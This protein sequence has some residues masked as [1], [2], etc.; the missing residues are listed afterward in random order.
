M[1]IL[2]ED[3][4]K[5]LELNVSV[6][7]GIILGIE[8]RRIEMPRDN[9]RTKLVTFVSLECHRGHRWDEDIV[10]LLKDDYPTWCKLC[11]IAEYQEELERIVTEKGGKL[12]TNYVNWRT[13]V[14]VWCGVD[15]HPPWDVAPTGIKNNGGWC[16]ICARSYFKEICNNVYYVKEEICRE[17]FYEAFHTEFKRTRS[18]DFMK[19][20]ELDGYSSKYNVAFEYNGEQHYFRI[21]HFQ[22]TSEKFKLQQ[23][24]DRRK[25]RRCK[26]ANVDL[27]VIPY[28]VDIL[29]IRSFIRTRLKELGWNGLYKRTGTDR[30]FISHIKMN[31][32]R[33]KRE[34]DIIRKIVEDKGSKL[35]SDRYVGS[36]IYVIVKCKNP[37]HLEY[38]VLPSSIKAG[39]DCS[40]CAI[41]NKMLTIEKVQAK[42]DAYDYGWKVVKIVQYK[43]RSGHIDNDFHIRFCDIEGHTIHRIQRSNLT[44]RLTSSSSKKCP[45]C[46]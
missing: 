43:L 44:G 23:D 11:P 17:V 39:T 14:R 7:K 37:N 2:S 35:I 8:K 5:C 28:T 1:E 31:G 32:S 27:I 42:V 19:G 4:R 36:N 30:E 3:R 33:Q 9:T 29:Q 41:E 10:R 26:R 6:R 16:P 25:I 22:R 13:K 12:L 45:D 24:R 40:D 18:V 20:L 46:M 34:Y 21:K 38:K 15:D